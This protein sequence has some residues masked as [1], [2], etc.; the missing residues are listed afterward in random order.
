VTSSILPLVERYGEHS[1]SVWEASQFWKQFFEAS[2]NVSLSGYEELAA[3]EADTTA[4]DETTIHD[5]SQA[6]D[7]STRRPGSRGSGTADDQGGG[8]QPTAEA[9]RSVDDSVL[10]DGSGDLSGSTPRPPSTKSTAAKAQF[11]NLGSPYEALK[12]ELKGQAKHKS[13]MNEAGEDED[14]ESEV[15]V[16]HTGRLP[17]MSMTPPTSV[18]R[19]VT[20]A[21]A[22]VLRQSVQGTTDKTKDPL[23]HR[24]LDKNYRLQATPHKPLGTS[25]MKWKMAGMKKQID[26]Q[27][28]GDV[29]RAKNTSAWQDS[30]MSS[31]EIPPPRLRSEAFMSPIRATARGRSAA[32][33][34]VPRTPGL[35]VQTPAAQGKTRDLLST[36]AGSSKR[37][38]EEINWDSDEDGD[39]DLYGGMSPPKTIQFALPPSKLLQTPGNAQLPSN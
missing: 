28:V 25:P 1:K 14:T 7:L 11:A 18:G 9:D 6:L 29:G 38:K 15:L 20:N 8:T 5:D 27:G 31:P 2:A 30:L 3:D 34:G 36:N 16:R 37:E 39:E 17:D 19:A 32:A 26:G 33:E 13:G 12:K 4:L 22:D 35:S 24:I 23:L 10:G 21:E